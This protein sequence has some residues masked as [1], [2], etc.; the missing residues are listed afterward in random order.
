[1]VEKRQSE[2][3]YAICCGVDVANMGSERFRTVNSTISFRSISRHQIAS[4]DHEILNLSTRFVPGWQI[5]RCEHDRQE[6]L[7]KKIAPCDA[8]H[9]MSTVDLRVRYVLRLWSSTS[10]LLSFFAEARTP[11][12]P[13]LIASTSAAEELGVK[14]QRDG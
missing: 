6:R 7:E 9:D 3:N 8:N 4:P 5:A 2:S 11:R 12:H 10:P 13:R 14:L 1:M